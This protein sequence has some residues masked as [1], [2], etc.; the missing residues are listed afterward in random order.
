MAASAIAS[1]ESPPAAPT[2]SFS[3]EILRLQQRERHGDFDHALAAIGE[4][5]DG[6]QGLVGEAERHE[7]VI[8]LLDD[9]AVMACGTPEVIGRAL[10]LHY[11]ARRERPS[12]TGK[13]RC[14]CQRASGKTRRPTRV[15]A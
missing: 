15:H 12:G 4:F 10:A 1:V 7:K 13:P 5:G 2:V 14:R 8:G 11:A 9:G 6:A 3:R